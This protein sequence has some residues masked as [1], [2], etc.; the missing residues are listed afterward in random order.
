MPGI[1]RLDIAIKDV[2]NPDHVGVYARGI[3]GAD[4]SKMRSSA[5][6]R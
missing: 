4:V 1:Y 3:N 2:N 6:R 5:P